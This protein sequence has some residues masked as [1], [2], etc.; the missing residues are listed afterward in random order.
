MS[1]NISTMTTDGELGRGA[2]KLLASLCFQDY[3]NLPAEEDSGC[4]PSSCCEES[5]DQGESSQPLLN[6]N[7]YQFC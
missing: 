3:I 6:S 5:C 1:S 2:L 4:E 7:N